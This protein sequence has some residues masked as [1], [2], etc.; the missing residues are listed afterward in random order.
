MRKLKF[1]RVIN[2]GGKIPRY[3]G[4]AWFDP[5]Y[6]EFICYP[7]G[8]N[9]LLAFVRNL[10]FGIKHYGKPTRTEILLSNEIERHG[11]TFD[12][13]LDARRKLKELTGE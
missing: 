5:V 12:L 9:V 11:K 6:D 7:V 2:E 13:L 10:W 8:I 1:K 4:V 3:C